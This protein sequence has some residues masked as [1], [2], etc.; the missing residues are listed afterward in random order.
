MSEKIGVVIVDDI[1]ET[2]EHLSKLLS[3]ENDIEV[4]GMASNGMEALELAARLR[5][6]VVLMDINMP[7]MDG[8]AT[9]EKLSATVPTAAIVMMSERAVN[10]RG[11][12]PNEAAAMKCLYLTTRSLDPTGHGRARW[13][14]RWKPALNAF[15]ITFADRMPAAST[16]H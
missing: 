8:I 15:A 13:V 6:D 11:H 4:V 14:V 3:F 7:G 5:P 2:R 16:S 1:P 10:A 9:T 12:F